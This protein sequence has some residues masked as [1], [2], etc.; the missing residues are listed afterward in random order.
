MTDPLPVSSVPSG[1][2]TEF[3][4]LARS[5]AAR[6]ADEGQDE[7]SR[8]FAT[9]LLAV[10]PDLAAATDTMARLAKVFG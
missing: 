2:P 8:R 4:D 9:E 6:A 1:L 7:F 5:L 10:L 3:H